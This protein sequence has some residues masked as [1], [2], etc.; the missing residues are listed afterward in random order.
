LQHQV[1]INGSHTIRIGFWKCL[2]SCYP[3]EVFTLHIITKKTTNHQEK[4][5]IEVI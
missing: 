2:R 3:C 5:L 4:F 1:I